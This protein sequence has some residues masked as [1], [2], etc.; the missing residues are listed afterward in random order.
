METAWNQR[1]KNRL[2]SQMT[3]RRVIPLVAALL[4]TVGTILYLATPKEPIYQG[5]QIE[6]V[7]RPTCIASIPISTRMRLPLSAMEKVLRRRSQNGSPLVT[8]CNTSARIRHSVWL[9][10][11]AG[12]AGL[13]G[14]SAISFIGWMSTLNITFTCGRQKRRERK[15]CGRLSN[16]VKNKPAASK[17]INWTHDKNV[18]RRLAGLRFLI[19][20]MPDKG[21]TPLPVLRR[22]LN[23]EKLG[24][25][26]PRG[27]KRCCCAV[28]R[29]RQQ[30]GI[31]KLYPAQKEIQLI[32]K[33]SAGE[34]WRQRSPIPGLLNKPRA[35]LPLILFPICGRL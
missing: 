30:P 13:R 19:F 20:T 8:P 26:E 6:R 27:R 7:D 21:E 32:W 12:D 9:R 11:M 14:E 35:L 4:L 33:T 1:R 16:C 24:D 23:D 18:E 17:L 28:R 5:P 10:K 34:N 15:R 3:C 22:M 29:V 2:R 31:D 25:K